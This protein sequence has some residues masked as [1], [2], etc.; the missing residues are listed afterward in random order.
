MKTDTVSPTKAVKSASRFRL[1]PAVVVTFIW[2]ST[3][4]LLSLWTANPVTVNRTQIMQSQYI[5]T[6]RIVDPVK[7]TVEVL[8]FKQTTGKQA[9][10]LLL[11]QTVTLQPVRENWQADSERIFPVYRDKSGKWI[12]TPAPLPKFRYVDYPATD[13]IRKEIDKILADR[14]H[15]TDS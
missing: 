11:H 14:P 3:L 1:L 5:L 10:N 7:G 9:D 15:K 8:D 13:S 2:L 4:A 12:I 6:G